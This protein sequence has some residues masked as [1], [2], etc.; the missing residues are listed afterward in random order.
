MSN[1][2]R[3]AHFF[4]HFFPV[5]LHDYNVKLPETLVT[6]FMK[7]MSYVF[8][9]TFFSLPLII[10]LHWWALEFLILSPPLQNFQVV[11][12]L[13]ALFFVDG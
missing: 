11:L 7:E 12:L 5:V 10:T 1:F 9:F 8:S 3:A 4:V 13:V 6:R 2:A